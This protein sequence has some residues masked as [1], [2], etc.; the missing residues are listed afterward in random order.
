MPDEY[1]NEHPVVAYRTY[2]VK[3]KLGVRNIVKYTRRKS[4]DFLTNGVCA[5]SLI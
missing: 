4:P 2:Y 3:N 5:T 1:K